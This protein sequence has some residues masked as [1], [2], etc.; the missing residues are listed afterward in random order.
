MYK[1]DLC[2]KEFPSSTARGK[3]RETHA[4]IN[5]HQC[6]ICGKTFKYTAS[7]ARHKLI[8]TAEPKVKCTFCDMVFLTKTRLRKHLLVHTDSK[9]FV[10]GIC[11]RPFN[12]KDNLKVHMK[13]HL[14]TSGSNK[15]KDQQQNILDVVGKEEFDDGKDNKLHCTKDGILIEPTDNDE[16]WYSDPLPKKRGKLQAPRKSTFCALCNKFVRTVAEHWR[17]HLNIRSQQCPYCP[18]SFVHRSNF[19][20]HLNIHTR[21]RIYKCSV[22]DSEFNSPQGLNQHLETHLVAK[23][24][25]LQ[26]GNRFSRKSYLRIHRQRVHE[27]KIKHKC[28]V[29]DKQ[30]TN[31]EHVEKHMIVHNN[32]TLLP[33]GICRRPYKARKN[34]LRHMRTAHPECEES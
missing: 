5:A 23:H 25:C 32:E 10:C 14:K 4:T 19:L 31:I 1:C 22:C 30:F 28:L 21:Q 12:R 2:D 24:E 8:H 9:P 7:W 16:V 6:A 3:H 26:C 11:N 15:K 20:M 27:P 34:L 33:C 17:M 18:K 13:T 29:C